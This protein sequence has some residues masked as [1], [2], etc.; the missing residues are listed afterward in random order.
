MRAGDRLDVGPALAAR[1]IERGYAAP[2]RGEPIETAVKKPTEKAVRKPRS[3][4]NV[5]KA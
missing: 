5:D 1:L 3:R 4:R 2:D